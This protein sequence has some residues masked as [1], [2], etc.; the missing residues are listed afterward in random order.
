VG[1]A[2]ELYL[3]WKASPRDAASAIA[4]LAEWQR[5]L[6]ADVPGLEAR[7]LLRDDAATVMEVYRVAA[8]AGG[9]PPWLEARVVEAGDAI[10]APWRRGSRHVERFVAR[11]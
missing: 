5:R 9:V 10:T 7:V 2:L 8:E 6:A 11:H 3:Y 4:A 1:G